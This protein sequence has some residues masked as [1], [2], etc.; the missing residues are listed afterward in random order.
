MGVQWATQNILRFGKARKG[1]DRVGK[2]RIVMMDCGWMDDGCGARRKAGLTFFL[3]IGQDWSGLV[4]FGRG[5]PLLKLRKADKVGDKVGRQSAG[6]YGGIP[7]PPSPDRHS[8]TTPGII[9][10]F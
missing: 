7:T 6:D 9:D 5:A 3:R 2:V 8:V 10:R 1:A 4:R